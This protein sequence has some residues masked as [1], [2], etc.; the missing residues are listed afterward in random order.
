[1]LKSTRIEFRPDWFKSGYY[2]YVLVAQHKTKGTFYYVG[3]TG[4]RNHKAARAPFYRMMGHFNTYNLKNKS[5]DSQ[6]IKGLKDNLLIE[7][8]KGKQNIRVSVEEVISLRQLSITAEFFQVDNFDSF[9][10]KSKQ[11]HVES[12]EQ[13]LLLMMNETFPNKCFNQHQLNEKQRSDL[14]A[15]GKAKEI[16]EQILATTK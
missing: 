9:D 3:M 16:Y 1:M 7:E 4:D 5:N 12:I 10:H 6:L 14:I 15:R 13:H 8:P 2:V 11:Q